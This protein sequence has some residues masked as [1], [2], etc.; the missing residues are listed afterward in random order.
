MTRSLKSLPEIIEQGSYETDEH[1]L[2]R[3]DRL[4]AKAKAE[5][6]I[7]EKFDVDFCLKLEGNATSELKD[8]SII[9]VK[10]KKHFKKAKGNAREL[11]DLE[12][13]KRKKK[14]QS[15]KRRKRKTR[16]KNDD[17]DEFKKLNDNVQF[18]EVVHAPPELTQFRKKLNLKRKPS[19]SNQSREHDRKNA[20]ELYRQ[21]KRQKLQRL[22]IQQKKFQSR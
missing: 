8:S 5:A 15:N 1:F 14:E 22:E 7:E 20:V 16:L 3:I 4:A 21:L 13:K 10:S 12:E 19:N 6:A 18:G 9:Q 17:D 11:E 2:R